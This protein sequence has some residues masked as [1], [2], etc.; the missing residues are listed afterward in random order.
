MKL[1]VYGTDEFFKV[2]LA[3][4]YVRKLRWCIVLPKTLFEYSRKSFPVA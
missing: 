3:K 2:I 1:I 4:V